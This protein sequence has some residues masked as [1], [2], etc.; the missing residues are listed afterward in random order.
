MDQAFK[1]AFAARLHKQRYDS[2]STT[3]G[4]RKLIW[5]SCLVRDRLVALGLRR[6][7]LLHKSVPNCSLPSEEDFGT[8]A[9]YPQFLD[10][11][12]KHQHIINFIAQCEL[13]QVMAR[14]SRFQEQRIYTANSP[15]SEGSSRD[16]ELKEVT[17][18]HI[19]LDKCSERFEM[20]LKQLSDSVIESY[21]MPCQMTRIYY[22]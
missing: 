14:I 18:F 7:H 2:P 17:S 19:E 20:A 21:N 15:A 3:R 5:W 9:Q 10:K 22:R 4:R 8:E 12:G 13:S 1:N 16:S 11:S 6:F